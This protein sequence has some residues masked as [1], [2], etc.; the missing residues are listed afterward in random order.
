M[1]C[2]LSICKIKSSLNKEIIAYLKEQGVVDE[3][4][5]AVKDHG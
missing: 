3:S 1:I 5:G 4:S 2:L